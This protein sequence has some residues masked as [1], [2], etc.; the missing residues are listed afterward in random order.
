M[1]AEAELLCDRVVMI[2]QGKKVLDRTLDE[3][4][5]EYNPRAVRL[6]PLDP[7]ASVEPLRA[8]PGVA[9]IERHNDSYE[10]KLREGVSLANAMRDIAATVA[11]ALLQVQRPT[12]EDIFVAIVTNQ[13]ESRLEPGGEELQQAPS[14]GGRS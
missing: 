13:G 10:L 1:M 11:P 12:L 2:H 4:R 9:G 8:L 6:E 7:A 3:I 14:K 5:A